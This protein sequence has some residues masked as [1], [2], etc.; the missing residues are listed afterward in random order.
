MTDLDYTPLPLVTRSNGEKDLQFTQEVRVASAPAAPVKL[1]DT[2]TLKWQGGVFLFTQNYDQSAVNSFAPFVLS[3]LL[4]F[5]VD[6]HSPEAALDDGGIGVYGQGTV[7]VRQQDRR[8]P[9]APAFDYENKQGQPQHLLRA[10]D[11][12]RPPSSTPRSRSRTSRR[13][14]RS[15]IACTP[16]AMTYVSVGRGFKAG[17]FNPGVAAGERGRTTR[18]TPGTS[19]AA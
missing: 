6:Q 8:S 2:A 1:S 12:S 4:P 3:P 9:S 16:D 13:S 19:R 7:D 14:L 17:G 10:A 5:S 18:S 11:L 15:A